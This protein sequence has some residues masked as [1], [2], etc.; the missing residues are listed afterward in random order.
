VSDLDQAWIELCDQLRTLGPDVVRAELA[1]IDRAEGYRFVLRQLRIAV[2]AALENA[3]PAHPLFHHGTGPDKKLLLDN[4]DVDYLVAPVDPAFTYRVTGSV[5]TCCYVGFTVYAGMFGSQRVVSNRN[6]SDLEIGPGG[7]I[8]LIMSAEPHDGNW[9]PLGEGAM[10]L[11][12]RRYFFDRSTDPGSDFAIEV[13]DPL[14]VETGPS[15]DVMARHLQDVG[16]LTHA[17]TTMAATYTDG[18][19]QV[20]NQLLAVPVSDADAVM[21]TPDNS[22]AVGYYALE[23]GTQLVVEGVPPEARYWSLYLMN[24]WSESFRTE[25]YPNTSLNSS[26]VAYEP[27]GSFRIVISAE[28]PTGAAN[29]LNTHG[30]TEGW[31]ALRW[32]CATG[33]VALPTCH[34]APLGS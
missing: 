15:V 4:P 18:V 10:S 13:I 22:Y 30:R 2:E 21:G 5:G 29:W 34:V 26:Q 8:D 7:E 14:P 9:V 23:P 28:R 31:M 16:S 25:T 33:E 32:L 6:D 19:S 1:D 11:L 24:R 27:D 3:D 20:P 17:L 12:V